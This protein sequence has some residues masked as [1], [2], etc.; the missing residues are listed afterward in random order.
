MNR[1]GI[2]EYGLPP[3]RQWQLP[4]AMKLINNLLRLALD[5]LQRLGTVESLASRQEPAA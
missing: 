4:R 3:D 1:L 5:L 2:G